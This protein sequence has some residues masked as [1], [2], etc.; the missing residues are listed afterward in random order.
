MGVRVSA[1]LCLAAAA[2]GMASCDKPSNSSRSPHQTSGTTQTPGGNTSSVGADA[3]ALLEQAFAGRQDLGGGSGQLEPQ[4]GNT[5]AATPDNVL[6]VTF[7]FV[8][9]GGATLTLRV[10]AASITTPPTNPPQRCDGSIIQQSVETPKP[11]PVSFAGDVINAQG[12]S[13]A[14]GYYTEKKQLK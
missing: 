9:T 7:G 5:L 4:I 14:Y 10:A 1:A 2:C 13:Y 11:G 8:C 6:S 3:Q 12:G